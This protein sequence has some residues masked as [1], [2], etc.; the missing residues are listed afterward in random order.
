MMD[1]LNEM[2]VATRPATHAVHMPTYY[3][4]KYAIKA[5]DFPNAY[6]ADQCSISLPLFHGM[7]RDEQDHVIFS[8]KKAFSKLKFN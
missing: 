7:T 3:R 2:G 4:E 5:E 1:K 8:V 6:I